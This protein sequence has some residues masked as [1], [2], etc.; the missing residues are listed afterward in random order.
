V[1]GKTVS[2]N[3]FRF[4]VMAKG[5]DAI[6]EDGLGFPTLALPSIKGIF[7]LINP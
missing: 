4:V 6:P 7:F 1:A 5:A 2:I 3:H